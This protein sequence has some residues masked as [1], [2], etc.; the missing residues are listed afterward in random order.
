[1]LVQLMLKYIK[2]KIINIFRYFYDISVP[3]DDVT[4]SVES[5]NYAI[6]ILSIAQVNVLYLFIYQ[7]EKIVY[8]NDYFYSPDPYIDLSKTCNYKYRNTGILL[9]FQNYQ[10]IQNIMYYIIILDYYMMQTI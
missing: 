6:S 5:T 1:M 10:E 4:Y 7:D 8:T 9:Y 3:I 2:S